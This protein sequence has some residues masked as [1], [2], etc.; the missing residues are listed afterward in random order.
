MLAT[1]A[2]GTCCCCPRYTHSTCASKCHAE[3]KT[4][5]PSTLRWGPAGRT[6]PGLRAGPLLSGRDRPQDWTGGSQTSQQLLVE[7]WLEVGASG[8][9]WGGAERGGAPSWALWWLHS[10]K[11]KDT[12]ADSGL[13]LCACTPGDWGLGFCGTQ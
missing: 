1:V 6:R 9:W 5:L 7:T 11:G 4:G 2:T 8:Y 12:V 3:W 10:D 13:T